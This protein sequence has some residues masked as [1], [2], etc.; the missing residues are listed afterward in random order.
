[1]QEKGGL[2]KKPKGTKT[3]QS[4]GAGKRSKSRGITHRGEDISPGIDQSYKG[5]R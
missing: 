1:M 4:T 2:G 3:S 5:R